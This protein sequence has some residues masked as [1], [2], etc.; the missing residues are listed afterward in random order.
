MSTE[1]LLTTAVIDAKQKRDV[2][3]LDVPNIFVQTPMPKSLQRVIMR[4][5]GLLVD[6]LEE[7]CPETYSKY[8]THQ[9]NTKVLYVG[10]KKVFKVQNCS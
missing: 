2:S 3:T 9:N 5:S 7:I 4:I 6:Y 10:M 8:I 1:A